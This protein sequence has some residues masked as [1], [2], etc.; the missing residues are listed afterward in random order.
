M[1]ELEKALRA[2]LAREP[3]PD[4]FARRALEKVAPRHALRRRWWR[5][6]ALRWAVAVV[7]VAAGVAGGA[8]AYQRREEARGKKAREQV[9]LALRITGSKLHAI[10]AEVTRTRRQEG[11]SQ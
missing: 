6:T 7:V 8:A 4:G 3:A 10:R 5:A 1:D 11:V 9:L 2:A